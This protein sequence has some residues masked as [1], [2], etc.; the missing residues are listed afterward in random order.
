MNDAESEVLWHRYAGGDGVVIKTTGRMLA[1]AV[2]IEPREFYIGQVTYLD[3]GSEA[4]PV[5]AGYTVYLPFLFKR[6]EFAPDKEVRMIMHE[7]GI[8]PESNGIVSIDKTPNPPKACLVKVDPTMLIDAVVLCPGAAAAVEEEVRA[9]MTPF[10]I[11]NRVSRSILE[12]RPN[13]GDLP[14]DVAPVS[15]T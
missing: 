9:I 7:S 8:K 10:G 15:E 1:N 4:I 12:Q 2:A 13:W 14:L 5:P 3:Y 11:A 6:R